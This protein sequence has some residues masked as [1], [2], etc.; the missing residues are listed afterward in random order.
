VTVCIS[1][2][3]KSIMPGRASR[4]DLTAEHLIA[5]YELGSDHAEDGISRRW[6]SDA[7]W[8]LIVHEPQ[9]QFTPHAPLL[10]RNS[11]DAGHRDFW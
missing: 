2:G 4:R 10:L 6:S 1:V 5:A 9:H 8:A 3:E 11:Y 7:L